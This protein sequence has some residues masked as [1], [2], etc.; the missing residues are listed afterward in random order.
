VH[1]RRPPITDEALSDRCHTRCASRLNASQSL[2]LAFLIAEALKE[3]RRRCA[4]P[5]NDRSSL[6]N[7]TP[8][9]GMPGRAASA[10]ALVSAAEDGR[11]PSCHC[12]A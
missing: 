4:L 7:L 6:R 3:Q 2:E 12:R 11:T 1:R 10:A 8:G 5:H 9:L